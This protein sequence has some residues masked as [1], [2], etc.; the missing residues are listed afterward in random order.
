[1]RV[2]MIITKKIYKILPD[3]L[4]QRSRNITLIVNI[5]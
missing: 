3:T 4:V 5:S 2:A 1:M